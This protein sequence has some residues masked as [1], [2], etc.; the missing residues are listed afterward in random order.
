MENNKQAFKAVSRI[1]LN[2]WHYIDAK[3]LDLHQNINF[4][5]GH[6]G[7][8]KSTVIDALQI[9]LYANTDGR[10]FFNK[11]AAD[12][13][14]RSLIEYLRGMINIGENGQAKYK[15]NQNFSTTI[16][17][18]LN[19]TQTHEKECVGV[20]FDVDV[21]SNDFNRLFFW[22]RGSVP[23]D[24]Y[25]RAGRVI[26]INE[27]K[28]WLNA[29]FPRED[30]F[31]TTNNERFRRNLYDCYL[32][33]LDMEKFPRLFKRAIPFRMNIRLEDFVKEYIC[34]EQDIHIEEM[35]ESVVLY[36]RMRRKI[37]DARNELNELQGIEMQFERYEQAKEAA[38]S[39][40]YR[41]DRL[42]ILHL[43]QNIKELQEHVQAG[44]EDIALKEQSLAELKKRRAEYQS[45]YDEIN[46]E[47]AGSGYADLEAKKNSLEDNLALLLRSEKKWQE[48]AGRLA[49]WEEEEIA[50][51]QVLWDIEKFV[52]GRISGEEISRLKKGLREIKE[53]A[54]KQKQEASSELRGLQ[55]EAGLLEQ[56]LMEL[57]LGKKAYPKELEA[58][59]RELRLKLY[60]ETGRD[61]PVRILADLL[62]IRDEKWR[63]A[64]EGYLGNNKLAL[65]V[66]PR[67]VR[68][69]F[70]AYEALGRRGRGER[71]RDQIARDRIPWDRSSW[72]RIP[73]DR[74]SLVDTEALSEKEHLLKKGSLAEEVEA[75]EAYVKAFVN[76]LL[77]NVMKCDGVEELRKCRVG[78]TADCMLYQSYQL[79]RLNPDNYTRRAF[80]G[81]KSMRE[82]QKELQ[83]RLEK[84]HDGIRKQEAAIE[85]ASRLLDMEYLD[86]TVQEY[87]DWSRDMEEKQKK[88]AQL[89]KISEHMEQIGTDT[90]DKLKERL[91][92][93]SV[94][95]R[96]LEKEADQLKLQIHDHKAGIEQYRQ[97]NI[98]RNE[99]L[100]QCERELMGSKAQEEEFEEFLRREIGQEPFKA[101]TG[102]GRT[103][104][105]GRS[106]SLQMG[107]R[108]EPDYNKL[109][110]Q[111]AEA[112]KRAQ[113]KTQQEK[114]R[115]VDVRSDYLKKH[116]DRE[117]SA[118]AE[119][120]EAYR[121]LQQELAC[122]RLLTYEQK[123]SQQA[124]IAVEHFKEDFIYK[125]RSAIKEAYIRRD[126]LNKIIRN[127]NFG[128]DRYQFK[129]TRSKGLLGEYYD[130]FM[131]ETLDI[132]PAS[133][134]QSVDSQMNMFSM[135]HESKYGVLMNDLIRIFL[136]PE[137]A[138]ARE[139]E[140]A[141]QNMA[142]YADYRS[143]LSFEMEQIVEGE[144]R[145]V[146]GLSKMIKKNSGGEGQNPLYVALLASFAQA[147]HINSANQARRPTLRLVIL[148][149][150]FSKMDAEKVA[151]CI[152]LIRGLGFQAI[153]SAT[154]DKIQ[155]YLENVD[156][157]FV[158]ANPNK[159]SISIQEFEKKE[160]S[161]LVEAE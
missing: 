61:V 158:Y 117:F 63:N 107:N 118:S 140:E 27:L 5:T 89:E 81:E 75:G 10:G 80:I 40:R 157:T 87:L 17:L 99:E 84:L 38:D 45:Q 56:D 159:K 19:Q 153:I 60:E 79:R 83:A 101:K 28:A 67:Y 33:G 86:S 128:K 138:S 90:V 73:W 76:Y 25:R 72:D 13:S 139:Q 2:N 64:I 16:V 11:A 36:G 100:L 131:D 124:K 111:A 105:G 53:E 88:E 22:H 4:F 39:L 74:I 152:E 137:N 160:F 23:Q 95:Q 130:M 156:K 146:I 47:L 6:S 116:P 66:E 155:N 9:V 121:A 32:G 82:R 108:Q 24:F 52:K 59:R 127:L 65:I 42:A 98:A 54:E 104:P 96:E 112:I 29:Q 18:E 142:K 147:Y 113:E 8:G 30:F 57:K 129:I 114:D 51:N 50:S 3:V 78:V 92:L 154:N 49:C 15:R 69:A 110:S 133:L 41:R 31:Y 132:N 34:M 135:A 94:K 126:E 43:Q 145:L 77:G 97:E 120:N 91:A 115:L 46:R 122:D 123:A 20:I 102:E 37:E 71:S 141:L 150:A 14:D 35:Q 21:A 7:S 136:P 151:S 161:Q 12:D 85:D 44:T 119:D 134:S 143:Y 93:V 62:D 48:T 149:E 125:I 106:S 26:T 70:A 148:D 58:A 1:V 144:D 55:K 103:V 68:Q 109:L